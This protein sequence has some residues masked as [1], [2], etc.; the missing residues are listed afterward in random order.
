MKG[1]INLARP[2]KPLDQQKGHLT[3]ITQNRKQKEEQLAK[4]DNSQLETP[5]SWLIDQTAIDEYNR[6]VKELLSIGIVGNLDIENLGGYA[7]AFSMYVHVTEELKEYELK[8]KSGKKLKATDS[9]YLVTKPTK[10]GDVL[11]ANPLIAIQTNYATEMRRFASLCGMT[12][13]ARLKAAT[14]I[15][16]DKQEKVKKKFGDI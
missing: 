1:G 4:C 16:E 11:V 14:S 8:I 12:V 13:D 10:Y 6:V 2:R 9:K 5:P 3:V 15:I 7:N